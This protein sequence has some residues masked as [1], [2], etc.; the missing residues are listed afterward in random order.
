[1]RLSRT[2]SLLLVFLVLAAAHA[3]SQSFLDGYFQRVA[4]EQAEQPHWITPVFTVTPR[5]EQEIRYDIFWQPR[6][7]GTTTRN[8]GGGKGLELIPAKNLEIIIGIPPYIA[9]NNPR[10]K[11]GWGDESFLVKYRL[12]SKNEENGNYIVTAF[13]GA[14]V[15]TG[16]YKN[17]A[18]RAV[19]TPTLALGKGWGNFDVVTTA[20]IQLP[21]ADSSKLG[22]PIVWN[23]TGQYRVL[24]KIWPEVEMNSTFFHNGPNRGKQQVFV[25]PGLVL[26]KFPIWRRLGATAGAGVQ[27]A[28]THFHT[29]NHATILTM[30]LPF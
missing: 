11:D 2:Y 5:L 16:S 15:P 8:Y 10:Q 30:R 25:T 28:A 14:T 29:Y 4:R 1:M 23:V 22:Q 7:D 24:R 3:F 17:G 12:L 18:A 26:G 19:I 27:I 21:V 9:H 20:G 6:A 13:L